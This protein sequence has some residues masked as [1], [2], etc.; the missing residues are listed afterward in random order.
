MKPPLPTTLIINIS[1]A[2]IYAITSVIGQ[3]FGTIPPGNATAIWAPSGI[4]LAAIFFFGY[5]VAPG[6]ALGS[7]IGNNNLYTPEFT[8]I[9]FIVALA[10]GM[11][12][13]I[14]GGLGVYF[15]KRFGNKTHPFNQV[16]SVWVFI[17][18]SALASCLV[19]ATIGSSSLVL[20]G[21]APPAVHGDLWLT[22]WLGDAAGV[23]I[24]APLLIVWRYLPKLSNEGRDVLEA[25]LAF[26]ALMLVGTISFV[27]GFPVEYLLIPILVF[28]VLR[29]GLHGA[30]LGVFLIA[31]FAI[32]GTVNGNGAFIREN[33]N[34]SLLL[35]QAFIGT[36]MFTALTLS[37]SD[38][39]RQSATLALAETNRTLEKRVIERTEQLAIAKEVAESASRAKSLFIAQ[40]SHEFRT[41]L[42]A[43]IGYSDILAMDEVTSTQTEQLGFIKKNA[44]RLLGLINDVLDISKIEAGKLTLQE[45]PVEMKPF[46]E[47]ILQSVQSLTARKQVIISTHYHPTA[48]A[49]LM[50]DAAKVQQITVNL[51]GN[52]I[53]FTTQGQIT[54][55]IGADSADTWFFCVRDTG[56]G[57]PPEAIQTLFEEYKRVEDDATKDIEGTGLGLSITKRLVDFLGGQIDVQSQLRQGSAFTVTLP[58]HDAVEM[59]GNG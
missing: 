19:N 45:S 31:G 28:V 20:G 51:V 15:L 40:M 39:E 29:F 2:L 56:I 4:A 9:G 37:A 59:L 25:A 57:M 34:D 10:I 42:N 17:L 26:I 8:L 27:G 58:R 41:P 43:I 23:V 18:L 52:A 38:K 21:F 47:E 13:A 53:K 24:I 32:W 16:R 5:R 11:G 54:I 46:F 33:V 30:T 44:K 36:V 6:I 7:F 22:W 14:E 3:Q 1:L 48:P 49:R 50:I 35:L 12:A 55:E